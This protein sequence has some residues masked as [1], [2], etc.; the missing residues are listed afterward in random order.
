[1][2]SPRPLLALALGLALLLAATPALAADPAPNLSVAAPHVRLLPPSAKNTGAFMVIT[3]RGPRDVKLVKADNP[4]SRAT[5][6]HT[7][8]DEDGVKKMRQVPFITVPA[9]GDAVLAPGG[10]HVM[11]I[12]LLRPLREG[13]VIAITL[14]FDDGTRL[15]IDAPVTR[16][17]APAPHPK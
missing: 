3:N 11:L 14:S 16:P 12:D 8:V 7:H 17:V 15:V 10:L 1:M 9:G 4:V 13:E 5:E 2:P 6:L